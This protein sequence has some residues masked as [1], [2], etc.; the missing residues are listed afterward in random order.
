MGEPCNLVV[1]MRLCAYSCAGREFED[2]LFGQL[3]ICKSVV[4]KEDSDRRMACL[5]SSHLEA[6]GRM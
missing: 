4:V 3:L 2:V 1:E 6:F 5:C